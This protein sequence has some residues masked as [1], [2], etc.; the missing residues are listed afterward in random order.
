MHAKPD[1]RVFLKWMIAGSGSV[2]TDVILLKSIMAKPSFRF[3]IRTL[4]LLLTLS[5]VVIGLILVPVTVRVPISGSLIM[6]SVHYSEGLCINV[7]DGEDLVAGNTLIVSR[8]MDVQ[9]IP[10]TPDEIEKI[11]KGEMVLPTPEDNSYLEI[12][13]NLI[14]KLRLRNATDIRVGGLPPPNS[15]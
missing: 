12:R 15:E 1:L 14:Q 3:S 5:C 2:I 9:S 7:Y 10:V 6:N 13:V 11:L 4:L 8:K